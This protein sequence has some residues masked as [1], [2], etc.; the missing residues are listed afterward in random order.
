MNSLLTFILPGV[1]GI[2]LFIHFNKNKKIFD[3]VIT[4]LLFLLFSNLITMSIISLLNK[5]IHNIVE[6]AS[7]NL[8]FTLYYILV[9]LI[10]NF[11]LSIV[12]TV[13]DKYVIFDIEVENERKTKKRK[14]IKSN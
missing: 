1:F 4:Y 10:V 9:S 6:Y 14:N 8:Q 13:I 3:L 2:K 5:E 7:N 11:I 12:F